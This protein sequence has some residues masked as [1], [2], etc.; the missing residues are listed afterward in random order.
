MARP[1]SPHA[2]VTLAGTV[3][4]HFGLTQAE[5][6]RFMGVSRAL[7]AAVEAGHKN[8]SEGPRHRLWVLARALPPPDG[9]GPP[10]PVFAAEGPDG[11]LD[12]DP[13]RVRL[14]RCQ[15]LLARTRFE[16]SQRGGWSRGHARREWAVAALRTALL[17]PPNPDERLTYPGATP[18]PVADRHWL[19][20]LALATA[21]A[22]VPLTATTRALRQARLRGLEAESA[23]L[24]ALLA[25]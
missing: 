13:L 11:P 20:A 8:F 7:V 22:P 25:E 24:E 6:A 21:A 15:Y 12:P 14:R 18:D 23:A 19:D 4:A 5:L 2:P 17:E 16:L 9:Q 1:S 3:R 10:V